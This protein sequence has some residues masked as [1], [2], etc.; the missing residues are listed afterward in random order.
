MLT[1]NFMFLLQIRVNRAFVPH[2]TFPRLDRAMFMCFIPIPWQ[3]LGLPW[4]SLLSSG[5][6]IKS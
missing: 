3:T 1:F 6:L 5:L 2:G 4:M